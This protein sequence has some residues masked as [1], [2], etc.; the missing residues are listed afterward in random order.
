MTVALNGDGGDEAFAGY[1]RYTLARRAR[2]RSPARCP[3]R[4]AA[5]ARSAPAARRPRRTASALVGPRPAR[6]SGPGPA[7]ARALPLHG[8]DLRAARPRAALQR[9]LPARWSATC[10]AR[11]DRGRLGLRRAATRRS[12]RML[13]VDVN[14][15]LPDDL[16]VKMDIASMAHSLEARSPFLDHELMEFAASIPAALKLRRSRAK[17]IL[18]AA[19]RGWI[20]DPMLDGPEA[21][22][23]PADGRRLASRRACA[24]MVVETL[25]RLARALPRLLPRGGGAGTCWAATSSGREDHGPQLWTLMMLELWHGSSSMR[26]RPD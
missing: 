22:L 26:L 25:D 3:E 15:Y 9:R 6:G 13:D 10:R 12:T 1:D 14:T 24:A 11:P 7:G 5:T 17:V 18:R 21:R 8:L 4:A 2:P 19:L 23:R 16:L 20:P